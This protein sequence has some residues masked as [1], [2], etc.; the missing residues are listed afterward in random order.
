M[1][2]ERQFGAQSRRKKV[3]RGDKNSKRRMFLESLE[4]RR[5]MTVEPDGNGWYYPPIGKFTADNTVSIGP[6]EYARRSALQYGTGNP[7]NTRSGGENGSPFN[8]SEVE[9]NNVPRQ[10]QLI[11]LGT[12]SSNFSVANISGQLTSVV[13]T[14]VVDEDYY[15]VDL[16]AGDI[17]EASLTGNR[18]N[19]FDVSLSDSS[20][21]E[22]IGSTSN[23]STSFPLSSPLYNI[24]GNTTF[25]QIIPATGRYYVR[26]ADGFGA[27]S[28]KLRAFRN[29][30]ESEPVGTKQIIFLDFNGQTFNGGIFGVPISVRLPS[31]IDTVEQYG[32]LRSDENALIDG[33]IAGIK[34]NYQGTLPFTGNNGYFSA[35][36][37]PGSFD[38]EFQNSRD[39]PDPWAD[40]NVSRVIIGGGSNE[41]PLP[42][43]GIAQSVDVGNY[44]RTETAIVLPEAYFQT[45][46]DVR[47]IPRTATKSTLDVF[48]KAISATISHEMG[49][50]L[51]AFHQ[52]NSNSILALM[53]SGG[54]PLATTRIGVGFDGIFGTDDDIDIDFVKD[55]YAIAEGFTGRTDHAINM[56]YAL[57]TGMV[58]STITGVVYNDRNRNARQDTGD[59]GLANWTV[60]ADI[61]GNNVQDAGDTSTLTL[62]NGAYTL[63]VPAGTF[64]IRAIPKSNWV[65]T[66]PASGVARVSGGGTANFGFNIPS[67]VATGFKWLDINGD[68]I[69]DASE[70]GLA[71]VYIY[72]D[73]DGDQ[74]PD[75]GEPASITKADG[76]Y[77]LTPPARGT[78]S[79]RE[80]VEPGYVQT[81]P[82]SGQHVV[83]FDGTN[84]LR[85]Y[86]FGNNE[87]SD[88]G[89]AP[90]PYPTTRAANGASHGL[91]AGLRLGVNI[92]SE[93]DGQ[94]SATATGD[95]TT[96]ITGSN[97]QVID[98]E[99]GILILAPIVRGDSSNTI[100]VSVTNTTGTPSY[101]QGWIDFN[102]NGTWGDVANEQIAKNVLVANGLNN[103][104]FATP[105]GAV[106]QAFAR[107]RLSQDQNVAP[108]G[109]SKTGE[110]EDYAFSIVDGP[111]T[112]LQ[113]DSFTVARNSQLNPMDVLANDFALPNDPWTITSVSLGINGGRVVIDAGGKAVKYTPALSFVGRDE[114]TYTTTSQ[115]GRQETA[116]VTVTVALQFV[117]PVAV[118]DSFDV[119]TNS[120]GFPLS[121]L[122]NDIEGRGGAL[123]V[124]S[125]TDPD[126]GGS[127]TIGSGG[128]S[129]RY[130]P[131]RGFGGTEQFSYT[132][133]DATGKSTSARITVHTLQGARA[134]DE[135]EFSFQFLNS[136]NQPITE[137]RQG[138]TFKVVVYVDDLRPEK[139]AAEIP[140]RNVTDPGVYSA[141]LDV[142][143]SSG[144]VT[145]NAPRTGSSL[146]FGATFVA[147]YQT[148]IN[149]TA[150]TPGII[151][152][153]GAFVGS[154]SSFNKPNPIPV[155]VLD[156]TAS[157]AGIAEFVGDP[158]DRLPSSEVTF[159]NTPTTRV[160]NEQIRFGRATLEIVPSGV[161]FPFAVDDTRF[162]IAA[163]NAF[164][165]DVLTNDVRGTQPPVR[166]TS[167]TQPPNGQT[168]I[169]RNSPGDDTIT[170]VS[171]SN[172]V[173]LEQFK[174][175]ITDNR[176]F[177]STATVSLHVGADT[178]DDLIR[179]RLD[180]TDL[181]GV[182]ID[183]VIVGQ[184]F[185]LRGYVQ[186]IRTAAVKPGVFAAFQ[187]ILYDKG[188]V[189]VNASTDPASLGFQVVFDPA[190][191]NGKSG[192]I[193]VPGVVNEI[194][195]VQTSD[196]PTGS[197]EKLQFTIT[198]TAR[199]T[200]T[201]NF[202][203]DPADIKPFHDSLVFEPTTPLTP[204]Q[205]RY[206]SDSIRIVAAAGGSGSSG[207]EGNT[208]LTNAYDVNND[209]YVSPIDVLIL[210]NSMNTGSS[211]FLGSPATGGGSGESGSGRYF[212]DVNRDNYLSPLDALAVINYLNNRSNVA[213][214]EGEGA[215]AITSNS[216]PLTTQLVDV[217][218]T[219]K[220]ASTLF[221]SSVYGPM[222]SSHDFDKALALNDDLS[223]HTES[224]DELDFLDGLAADVFHNS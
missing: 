173:G 119:P 116:K 153:L 101:L 24:S 182:P 68:G 28:L 18:N 132:A 165:I 152:E 42:V 62:A 134:D 156:F 2:K 223:A 118:D 71:G 34:E 187:D 197:G 200:G 35:D 213:G 122:A 209:G 59:E 128:Q 198:L 216:T 65:V 199:N 121:V 211:G 215:P 6:A 170:Y 218:F 214:G 104:T 172:F 144:L 160:P 125:V 166:I 186:D 39:N 110:V 15:A 108:T 141:Y 162:N 76:S 80:V 43:R 38:I 202:L 207:G 14:N 51:G 181:S 7:G 97:G 84:P 203:G 206:L 3:L 100:Q 72:L 91:T 21:S 136:A 103:V 185:Q 66:A 33:I 79:I 217:P 194:G 56:A 89:D 183:Q 85:G 17:L 58:G 30:I 29:S 145:P 175:T 74:R 25:A 210:V 137:V 168:T 92:D 130:T 143:Y 188:L 107:F 36:G 131:A 98:D 52:E 192:D 117:D 126:K 138:E 127:V 195:S 22:I 196:G 11:P 115:S 9:P 161:D 111:R 73:L 27:Y 221:D 82:S 163:G 201:A 77:S 16:R 176:G 129:I 140:P 19:I 8:T 86:D 112:L 205:I 23:T 45:G 135:V 63:S 174:Y 191:S 222:P 193:R 102:G 146:D 48:V 164:N 150:K 124:S 26:V 64:N 189:S 41:F 44:N 20:G 142:L 90:A 32:F 212:L 57:E 10:A 158:A 5:L 81:Y 224:D 47:T 190:Y 159:Y 83:T 78:Y 95:D 46:D 169:N 12:L 204:N 67:D 157:S 171:N 114:F 69:R 106:T 133:T 151:D 88:W 105:S 61:N 93:Q 167:V 178:A 113:P 94:P 87:S 139:A 54:L 177:I 148:G 154:V 31:M 40:K 1:T 96:G 70:S 220:R 208:N 4:D 99:D 37:R 149:G 155:V 123:I 75:L 120:I 60:F 179:L 55:R 184:Q 147:P 49:H 53:D 50:Y 13:T 109:K 219:K 180:A